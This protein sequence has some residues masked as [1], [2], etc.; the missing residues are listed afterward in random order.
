MPSPENHQEQA[1]LPP[2][3]QR[4]PRKG[5]QLPTTLARTDRTW[6]EA[7]RASPGNNTG[8]AVRLPTY[9]TVEKDLAIPYPFAANPHLLITGRYSSSIDNQNEILFRHM[10]PDGQAA[11]R[12]LLQR[13]LTEAHIEIRKRLGINLFYT[14]TLGDTITVVTKK[15]D[16]HQGD[17]ILTG[18][19]RVRFPSP[20]ATITMYDQQRKQHNNMDTHLS[21][22]IG[23]TGQA[24]PI[25]IPSGHRGETSQDESLHKAYI[26]CKTFRGK[27]HNGI[28]QLFRD[29]LREIYD[30]IFDINA[31]PLPTPEEY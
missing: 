14:D 2:K 16:K 24:C 9:H 4:A 31:E 6:A 3:D 13:Y 26:S 10:H 5:S 22:L 20:R 21:R 8:T 11:T 7:A 12:E 23:H 19:I 18:D 17:W 29:N 25:L 30:K 1:H 28:Q 15:S 27:D